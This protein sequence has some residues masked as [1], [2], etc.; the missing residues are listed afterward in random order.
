MNR[1]HDLYTERALEGPF[2]LETF[3]QELLT[4]KLGAITATEIFDF[5]DELEDDMLQNVQIKAQELPYYE[6][7]QDEA[8]TRV[9]EQIESLRAR[10]RRAVS[11]GGLPA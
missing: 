3:I 1:L 4:G 6:A 8:E 9:R 5:L 7:N 2:D 11:G 10:V